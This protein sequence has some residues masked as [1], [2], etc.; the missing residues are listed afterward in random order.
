MKAY[1]TGQRKH[2][3][4]RVI[5]SGVGDTELNNIAAYY[6]RQTPAR[7]HTPLVGDASAGRG[8]T[9]LCAGCHGEHGT[10]VVPAW[11]SLAGQDS[12]YLADAIRSYKQ[13]SRSKAIACAACHGEGGISKRPGMP[14][15]VGLDPQYLVASM[16]AYIAG[17]R[18]MRLW[19]RFSRV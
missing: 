18:R 5:L 14:S 7:A 19:A 12:Q 11:P 10:S 8:A 16:K 2:S 4:M 9:A 1:I 6:A 17:Q 13:G 15:L 3:L